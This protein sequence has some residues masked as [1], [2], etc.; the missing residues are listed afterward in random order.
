MKLSKYNYKTRV[1]EWELIRPETGLD[2]YVSLQ[3]L[4]GLLEIP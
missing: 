2:S 4:I 3:K 1:L